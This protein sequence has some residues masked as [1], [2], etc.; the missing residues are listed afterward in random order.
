MFDPTDDAVYVKLAD[1]KGD[2]RETGVT[3][4]GVIVDLDA[5]GVCSSGS[6]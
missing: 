5:S 1:P 6:Y 2:D 3:E 4:D